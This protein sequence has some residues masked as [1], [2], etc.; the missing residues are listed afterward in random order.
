[1][2]ARDEYLNERLDGRLPWAPVSDPDIEGLV[3][4]AQWLQQAEPLQV[5]EDFA[6]R[7]ETRL[8]ARQA[9]LKPQT[10]R[11]QRRWKAVPSTTWVRRPLGAVAMLCALLLLLL[12][13]GLL[14][15]AHG[16]S[17]GSPL[18]GVKRWEGGMRYGLN[19]QTVQ[20]AQD[21][22][23]AH[24][25]LLMVASVTSPASNTKAYSDALNGF[26]RS[27]ATFEN[28]VSKFPSGSEREQLAKDLVS[29]KLDAR[30][31]LRGLL[32]HL[33]ITQRLT[34]TTELAQLGEPVPLLT[35]I[36]ITSTPGSSSQVVITF[37]G[38]NIQPGARLVIDGQLVTANQLFKG[39]SYQFTLKW[40]KQQAPHS[41]GI[42]NPDGMNVA[43]NR[44]NWPATHD[45]NQGGNGHGNGGGTGN[46]DDGGKSNGKGSGSGENP[47]G[48][49]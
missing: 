35:K 43:N 41:L 12:G 7:L 26:V 9:V 2:K 5:D 38:S 44:F 13:S 30:H 32:T 15:A 6:H 49:H 22:Q 14:V 16:A 24:D 10:A 8:L 46:G 23:E 4:Q 45:G 3:S 17:P 18:Y 40:E 27:L 48:H 29:L 19:A 33:T 21:Y 11:Q 25:R 47:I 39:G 1:M 36:I 37:E 20:A 42:Q 28:D 31:T 34:T